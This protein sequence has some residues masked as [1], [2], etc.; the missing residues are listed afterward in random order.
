MISIR[1]DACPLFEAGS[2][3]LTQAGLEFTVKP[4]LTL[5]SVWLTGSW[6]WVDLVL[7]V[8]RVLLQA[9]LLLLT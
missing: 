9:I 3:M 6:N 2:H 5:S 7:W 1:V 8:S 4:R